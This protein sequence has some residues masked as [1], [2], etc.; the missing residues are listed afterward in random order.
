DLL[1]ARPAPQPR[2]TRRELGALVGLT[3]FTAVLSFSYL[4]SMTAPQNP[5][6]ATN[7][8]LTETVIPAGNTAEIWLYPGISTGGRVTI[9]S[10]DGSVLYE[11]ELNYGTPFSWSSAAF[12][13]AAGQ[14]LTVTVENAQVFE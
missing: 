10:A 7:T 6:D 12:S 3:A 4:G 9:T 1:A 11:K 2:W 14:P 5:L 8:T 13:A